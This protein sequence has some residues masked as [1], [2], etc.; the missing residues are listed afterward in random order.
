MTRVVDRASKAPSWAA[1]VKTQGV[2][3]AQRPSR[4]ILP[5]QASA[6]PVER[7]SGE[8]CRKFPNSGRRI[9]FPIDGLAWRA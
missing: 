9:G 1:T 3:E 5:R 2:G 4:A 8:G 6:L 7:G